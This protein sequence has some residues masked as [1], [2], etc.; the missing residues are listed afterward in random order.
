MA[1]CCGG[2]GINLHKRSVAIHT[3]DAEGTLVRAANLPAQRRALTAYFGTLPGPH[4]AVVE[5]TGMWYWAP[6]S[7]RAAGD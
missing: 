7:P 1:F 4:P 6:G 5:C 3:L 2:T